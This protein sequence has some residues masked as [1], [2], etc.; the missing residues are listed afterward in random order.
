MD[1][2]GSD[3]DKHAKKLKSRFNSATSDSLKDMS[4]AKTFE[5]K[6]KGA[7]SIVQGL[8]A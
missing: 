1:L 8:L 7:K 5:D 4:K 2:K 6:V 3:F